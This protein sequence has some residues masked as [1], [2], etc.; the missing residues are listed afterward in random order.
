MEPIRFEFDGFNHELIE[1]LCSKISK[2]LEEYDFS[3]FLVGCT[4]EDYLSNEGKE[5]LRKEFQPLIVRRLEE[6]LGKKADYLRPDIEILINFNQDLVY[7]LVHSV[8]VK[9]RYKKYAKIYQTKHYCFRCKGSGCEE[10]KGVGTLSNES[11]EELISKHL[12]PAFDA[13]GAKM[14]GAGR[15]DADVRMLGNGREFVM[16]IISPKKRSVD[17]K[18]LEAKINNC[19]KEK[20]EVFG[21]EYCEKDYV[22]HIKSKKSRKV[23]RAKVVCE[24]PLEKTD[25]VIGK[26]E[27][28]QRT[29]LRVLRRRPDLVRKKKAE[30]RS[31]H[32]EGNSL[33][34]E[35]VADSGLYVKEFISGDNLRT[36]PSISEIIGTK[37]E[38]VELDVIEIIEQESD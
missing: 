25:I 28:K 12:I 7:F 23:Y 32:I 24:G 6:S 10:C 37:C 36:K 11:V 26:Y 4:F 19:E 38:C 2:A 14:H 17:L 16:Q 5:I 18:W 31:A 15:E 35:I 29:P 30:V 8:Y 9:G 21:L 33:I 34:I 3:G 13:E 20:I 22:V 27:I 1:K